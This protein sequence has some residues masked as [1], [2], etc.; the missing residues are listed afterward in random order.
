M[1]IVTSDIPGVVI[2]EPRV[3]PDPRGYFFE[4]YRE[5][6]YAEAG[7]G[8]HFVQD[9]I[10]RSQRNVLRGLHIQEPNGQGKLVQVLS[11]AIFDVG[12][13]VR[14][15]SPWFGRH[16]GVELSQ[17]NKR[18]FYIPPGFA[19]GFCVLSDDVLVQY[20]CTTYYSPKDEFSVLWSDPDLGIAWPVREPVLS[21]KDSGGRRLRDIEPLRLPAY[22]AAPA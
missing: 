8:P 1:N 20:K 9:N 22:A 17:D 6:D 2:V 15:G 19:H 5:S 12:L 7:I 10:S 16:V 4:S 14:R 3:F 18:Q 11:G 13:D 21:P